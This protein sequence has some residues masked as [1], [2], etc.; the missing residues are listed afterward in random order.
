MSSVGIRGELTT[1]LFLPD[2]TLLC[3]ETKSNHITN[4]GIRAIARAITGIEPL[5]FKTI[6][7]GTGGESYEQLKDPETG[8]LLLD[9]SGNPLMGYVFKII[10]DADTALFTYYSETAEVTVTPGSGYFVLTAKMPV[11][12]DIAV[13][14][15]GIFSGPHAGAPVML[16]KQ[17]FSNT[18][19]LWKA[20]QAATLST[21]IGDSIDLEIT[22]KVFFARDPQYEALYDPDLEIV[23][24]V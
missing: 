16:A 22:W 24:G 8:A 23:A 2:G 9:R 1:S 21:V 4:A 3:S 12:L 17:V 11:P 18:V 7:I 19:K 6:Q 13:N 20:R 14:E 15:A 10:P 5:V